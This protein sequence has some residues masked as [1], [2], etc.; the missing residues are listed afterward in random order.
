MERDEAEPFAKRSSST[1][2]SGRA[3]AIELFV[4]PKSTPMC[5]CVTRCRTLY[6]T[7]SA[8]GDP[9]LLSLEQAAV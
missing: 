1:R 9:S 6:S 7:R 8:T 5:V 4:V 3:R 2:P